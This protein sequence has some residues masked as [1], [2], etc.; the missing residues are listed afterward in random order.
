MV[1][2]IGWGGAMDL[3]EEQRRRMEENRA[4]AQAR[5]REKRARQSPPMSASE[6]GTG[7]VEGR[8]T[9]IGYVVGGQADA[10]RGGGG[11]PPPRHSGS[12]D[13]QDEREKERARPPPAESGPMGG[14]PTSRGASTRAGGGGGSS[15][16]RGGSRGTGNGAPAEGAAATI[17]CEGC[18]GAEGDER[19]DKELLEGFGII[20]CRACKLKN[21]DFQCVTKKEAK[22]TYLLPEG[23]IAVLKFIER[24]NPRHSSWT[25]MKLYLRRDVA[26]YSHK[27]W[28]SEEG[29]AEE[30]TR[31]ELLKFDR[32]LSRTKGVFK[33]PRSEAEE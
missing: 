7:V 2:G 18:T 33:R 17:A 15:Y 27:R 23:T 8:K 3:T 10:S 30:R 4:R 11:E 31:R 1:S 21:E 14:T 32:S 5:L 16:P 29:L 6:G 26:A 28:G 24:D 25:K 9:Q 19:V 12:P 13:P 20:V 22:D